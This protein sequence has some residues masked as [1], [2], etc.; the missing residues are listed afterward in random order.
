[1]SIKHYTYTLREYYNKFK[2]SILL[3]NSH[4]PPQLEFCKKQ[5][6]YITLNVTIYALV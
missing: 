5:T 1:M 4:P 6:L 2:T 3:T